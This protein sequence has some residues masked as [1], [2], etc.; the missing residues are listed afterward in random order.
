MGQLFCLLLDSRPMSSPDLEQLRA[1]LVSL[2]EQRNRMVHRTSD[3]DRR[4]SVEVQAARERVDS[5]RSELVAVTERAGALRF[6]VQEFE[7]G[8]PPAGDEASW[9][10]AWR[11]AA[12]TV[13]Q[14][15][16]QRT[17]LATETAMAEDRLQ[18]ALVEQ[19]AISTDHLRNLAQLEHE[20]AELTNEVGRLQAERPPI[21]APD[22]RFR[23][24]LLGR[25]THLDAERKWISEEIAVREERLRR[26]SSETAQIRSLLEMHTPD[27]GREAMESLAPPSAA[28][29]MPAW[30][31]GV[32][33]ILGTASQPLHYRQIAEMLSATGRSLGGQDPAETL[34]AALGRDPDFVRVGRGTYWL[35]GRAQA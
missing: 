8:Q 24:V 26:I 10:A 23:D 33:E 25:L 27:W 3:L 7:R 20:I 5:L 4:A 16:E 32:M 12:A 14:V 15:E 18:Q 13:A 31:L 6:Q 22:P 21:D 34:L 28:E 19:E 11:D 30:K 9:Q 1:R 29:R 17:R 2:R 35:K